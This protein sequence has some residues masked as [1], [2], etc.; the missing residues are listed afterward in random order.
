MVLKGVNVKLGDGVSACFDPDS[1]NY[2]AIWDGW[3]KFDSFRWGS[4]RNA[5]IKGKLRFY[6]TEPIESSREKLSRTLSKW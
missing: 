3:I 5:T 6:Q 1:L 4:S 2:R